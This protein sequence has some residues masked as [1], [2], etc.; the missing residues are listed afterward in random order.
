MAD[1]PEKLLSSRLLLASDSAASRLVLALML[2]EAGFDVTEAGDGREALARAAAEHF[3]LVITDLHMAP[4]DDLTLIA[5]LLHLPRDVP[6]IILCSGDAPAN[7][8]ENLRRLGI[9]TI[10]KPVTA[11]QLVRAVRSALVRT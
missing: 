7:V 1:S 8:I 4:L 2:S 6:K 3:D 9:S 11:D 5:G 10:H